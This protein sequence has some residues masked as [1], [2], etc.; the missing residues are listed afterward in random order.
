[1]KCRVAV[2]L[3][4]AALLLVLC[5]PLAASAPRRTPKMVVILVV[6]QMR[7]DYVEKFGQNWTGGLR[8]LMDE[9][10][11]FREAAYPYLTTVTCVGHSTIVTGSLPRTHG[12]VGNSWWDREA[13]RSVNC[14]ADA[15]RTLI[16]YGAPAR[17]GTSTRNL[18]VP[19]LPDELRVQRSIAP[20]IV[21][22]SLKDYTATMLAGRRADAA[23]W[24]NATAHTL[25]TSSAYTTAP[26]SFVESFVKA[27]PI[28]AYFGR[29]W[30]KL[31]PEAAY[32]YADDA[33]GEATVA[34]GTNKFPHLLRGP[35]DKPDADF[36]TA[37]Q[38]SPFSDEYLGLFAEAAIDAFKLG[39]GAGTDY[40]AVS[41]SALDEVGHDFGPRSHEIQ[42]VLARLDQTV[43]SLISH[44]DRA[45]GRQNYVLAFTADHGVAPIPE[46]AIELGLTGGRIPA[47]EMIARVEKAL[48]PSLGSGKKVAGLV[49]NGLYFA[50]GVFEKLQANPDAMRAALDAVRSTPGVARV[51]RADEVG[52]PFAKA[53]DPIEQAVAD[54][55]FAP[56]SGDFILVTSPN[57]FFGSGSTGTSHGSAY[58]YDQHVPLMLLGQ[59]IRA[60][61]YL[62]ASGPMDV[63]PTI[64][65]L[66]GITLAAPDGR[67]LNE[68][69]L[70]FPAPGA[71]PAPA[72][73][74]KK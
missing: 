28:D 3:V 48:E 50:P 37:W 70:P 4:F 68:A 42:D 8:R 21:T 29:A 17:G 58:G 51:F 35:G 39:Q 43:G 44:L 61:Q 33:P 47:A 63:A 7:A 20:R 23:V 12:I 57:F 9:G 45:V 46:Q 32:L 72:P 18:L 67:V 49:A 14:V 15:E 26:V 71:G 31:L 5:A 53:E 41:F 25:A 64:A 34:K 6:D 73:A 38:E 52:R 40:L 16:S 69:L 60:G 27:H 1:M 19:A 62:T 10:A 22:A 11:W 66:C 56:R 54:N 30:T 59:G 65:F 13:G 55:F 2:P 24:F 36:Y 74:V